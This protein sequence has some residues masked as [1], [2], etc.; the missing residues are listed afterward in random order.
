MFT[1]CV[2]LSFLCLSR[3]VRSFFFPFF[4]AEL[5]RLKTH[6]L[7][8]SHLCLSTHGEGLFRCCKTSLWIKKKCPNINALKKCE[9]SI[10]QQPHE[11]AGCVFAGITRQLWGVCSSPEEAAASSQL[12]QFLNKS[13]LV[14]SKSFNC[15]GLDCGCSG[16]G[17]IVWKFRILVRLNVGSII[18]EEF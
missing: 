7:H 1:I 14:R 9:L 10:N 5:G 12:L 17:E 2:G 18:S 15:R 4:L 16:F 6:L 11:W 3:I 13:L 8:I